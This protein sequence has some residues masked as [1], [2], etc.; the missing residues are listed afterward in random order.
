MCSSC[1]NNRDIL[2]PL[3]LVSIERD[4]VQGKILWAYQYKIQMVKENAHQAL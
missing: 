3:F 4:W 2:N 1:A